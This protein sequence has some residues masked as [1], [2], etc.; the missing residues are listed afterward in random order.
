MKTIYLVRHGKASLEGKEEERVLLE[1][2]VSQAHQLKTAFESLSPKISKL[3]SSPYVRAIQ[4]FQPFSQSSGLSISVV[5]EFH[6]LKLP[7]KPTDDKNE[8]RKKLWADENF[9][10]EGGESLREAAQRALNALTQIKNQLGEGTAAA[11]MSHGTLIGAMVKA[12]GMNPYGYEEWK[13]MGM[14]DI[15]RVDFEGNKTRVSSVGCIGVDA[16]R[17]GDQQSGSDKNLD[18]TKDYLKEKQY[19]ESKYLEARIAIHKFGASNE[20]FHSWVFR[21]LGINKPVRILDVG[22]GTA[23]F[24]KENY[25]KLPSGC[26]LV[27]TDFSAGMLEK[28]KK[29]VSGNNV[30]FEVAD[31]DRLPFDNEVF[32]MVL[33]HHVIYHAENKNKALS[34][35][36]RVVKKGGLVSITSNSEKHMF[37]VY[38][39]GRSLDPGFPTDRI[40]DSFTEEIADTLLL[41]FF[42]SVQKKISEEL[43]KVTD[44]EILINYVKSGVEPR[45]ISLAS[46]FWE[47]YTAIARQEM[48]AQGYFGIPKRSPLYL[49]RKA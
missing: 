11:V 19:K 45:N 29:N 10:T 16:F 15:F 37:N 43:L 7:T 38:E 41:R 34:E 39:I 26:T 2:G 44:M 17:I 27:L 40:I 48:D 36:Q 12:L 35:L 8:V 18:I 14:P 47:K 20:S 28:A 30:A 24:W 1:E 6:E 33:A 42:E 3:Y 32:D 5:N 25:S 13:A 9:K 31:I 4:S 49:C 23:E 22:A 46:G 21:H